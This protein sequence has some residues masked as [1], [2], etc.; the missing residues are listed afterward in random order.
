M[1]EIQEFAGLNYRP[2]AL[3]LKSQH[4]IAWSAALLA[5]CQP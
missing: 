1:N 3:D 4:L 5:D 2:G